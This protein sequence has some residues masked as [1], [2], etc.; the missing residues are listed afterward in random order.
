VNQAA[1]VEKA[2]QPSLN[3]EIKKCGRILVIVGICTFV[4]VV[5][6]YTGT[7]FLSI[8]TSLTQSPLSF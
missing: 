4:L 5:A 6:F 3:E 7:L 8:T 2:M 1:K